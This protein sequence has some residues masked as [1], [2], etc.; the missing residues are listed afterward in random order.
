MGSTVSRSVNA[1]AEELGFVF[2]NFRKPGHA[3]VVQE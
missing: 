3:S 1:E 2:A